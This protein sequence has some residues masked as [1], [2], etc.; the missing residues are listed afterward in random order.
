MTNS[1]K[2]SPM[3]LI[4]ISLIREKSTPV[5]CFAV[6]SQV[7]RRQAQLFLIFTANE[8]IPINTYWFL[9]LGYLYP[10]KAQVPDTA[11]AQISDSLFGEASKKISGLY[12]SY[13]PANKLPVILITNSYL[14]LI[15]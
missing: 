11:K 8:D 15:P 3:F 6:S 5:P 1:Y 14:S 2:N 13:I 10:A 9:L 7:Y 12:L 4:F